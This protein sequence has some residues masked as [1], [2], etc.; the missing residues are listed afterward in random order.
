MHFVNV[1]PF[2]NMQTHTYRWQFPLADSFYFP[3]TS[4]KHFRIWAFAKISG[5]K[6]LFHL[7]RA[8]ACALKRVCSKTHEAIKDSPRCKAR[9]APWR[10]AER[11]GTFPSR[12]LKGSDVQKAFLFKTHQWGKPPVQFWRTAVVYTRLNATLPNVWLRFSFIFDE[13]VSLRAILAPGQD[14]NLLGKDI[15]FPSLKSKCPSG[16]CDVHHVVL[17][18]YLMYIME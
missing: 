5:R 12:G 7:G 17:F 1:A 9:D 3:L 18:G 8:I 15:F 2:S 4:Q 10:S 13:S 11:S 6:H 16:V 14:V